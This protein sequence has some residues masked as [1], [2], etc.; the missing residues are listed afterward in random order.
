MW[1]DTVDSGT[2][3]DG[4][5]GK[6]LRPTIKD[7]P[8]SRAEDKMLYGYWIARSTLD[9]IRTD[10]APNAFIVFLRINMIDTS[11]S[12]TICRMGDSCLHGESWHGVKL[13][14]WGA[15]GDGEQVCRER[16]TAGDFL[17]IMTLTLADK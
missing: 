9:Q 1:V 2:E 12:G 6:E 17:Y 11:E 5:S 13:F 14:G 3:L 15:A 10:R 16:L 7:A 8:G 4:F